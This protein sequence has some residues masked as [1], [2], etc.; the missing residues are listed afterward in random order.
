[1]PIPSQIISNRSFNLWPSWHIVYEWEDEI[2]SRLSLEIVNRQDLNKKYLQW[3]KMKTKQETLLEKNLNYFESD[4]I[5]SIS[6]YSYCFE[7]APRFDLHISNFRNTI[8]IFVDYWDRENVSLTKEAY[9]KCPFLLVTSLEVINF[10]KAHNFKNRLIHFPIS[11]PSKYRISPDQTFEKKYDIVLVGRQNAVLLSFLQRY[12]NQNP[13]IEFIQAFQEGGEI[14][15]SSNKSGRM[16]K[17]HSREAYMSLLRATRVAFYSTPGIDGGEQRTNGFNPVTPR[18]LEILSAG[19]HVIARY[20]KNLETEFFN[21]KAICPAINTYS[22]F[23]TQL[24]DALLQPPPAQRNS[25]YLEN[26][27][28]SRRIASFKSPS[29]GLP[30]TS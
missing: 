7:M 20:P 6:K 3:L 24:H 13:E 25:E 16:G 11:L 27:Y 10:F 15:C 26:H 14:Y 18:F 23:V 19:C 4:L 17:C 8:P 5:P 28:T 2:A 30:Y 21:L 29:S 1:M 9:E 12:V 22:E